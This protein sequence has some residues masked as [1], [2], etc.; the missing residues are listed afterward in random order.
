MY[1]SGVLYYVFV[2]F[3]ACTVQKELLLSDY[4]I[5]S[6]VRILTFFTFLELLLLFFQLVP[7][8]K[9][10]MWRELNNFSFRCSTI[11]SVKRPWELCKP[12][13]L[14]QECPHSMKG[15]FLHLDALFTIKLR[16][17]AVHVLISNYFYHSVLHLFRDEFYIMLIV[18]G[19]NFLCNR[20]II[21]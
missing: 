14:D 7:R 12:R 2:I 5:A 10:Q 13:N 4:M 19:M 9:T 21:S 8:A 15:R 18:E 1:F 11:W 17:M 3:L 6:E 20:Y 16:T